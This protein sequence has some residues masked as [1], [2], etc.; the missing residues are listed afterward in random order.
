M[1]LDVVARELGGG[2]WFILS[3]I[4]GV[5]FLVYFARELWTKGTSEQRW[6]AIG[7][8]LICLGSSIRAFLLWMLSIYTIA[9]WAAE[10]WSGTWSWFM[11]SVAFNS[12]GS[13]IGIWVLLPLRWR[14]SIFAAS[15]VGSVMV[16]LAL[17][18]LI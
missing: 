2:N 3:T 6:L 1:N 10:T 18:Y 8:A 4:L 7:L 12:I 14:K 16:P 13:L 17:F 9:G 15:L 11:L 5:S